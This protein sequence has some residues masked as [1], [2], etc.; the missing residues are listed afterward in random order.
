MSLLFQTSDLPRRQASLSRLISWSSAS[1]LIVTGV[2]I[3]LLAVVILVY[4]NASATR[5][6]RLRTLERERTQ[7]LLSQEIINMEIAEQQSLM[8]LASDPQIL[9]MEESRRAQF[10]KP[11]PAVA[12]D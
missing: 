5:G 4:E 10:V 9:G 7:L 6:Y 1:L 3:I 11:I 2:L 8:N 12:R